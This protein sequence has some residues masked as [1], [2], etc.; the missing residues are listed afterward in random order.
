MKFYKITLYSSIKN[1]L[2]NIYHKHLVIH[3]KIYLIIFKFDIRIKKFNLSKHL[4]KSIQKTKT[5]DDRIQQMKLISY[6]L[7]L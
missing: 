7:F 5:I 1:N 2:L 4:Q 3:Q 6:G